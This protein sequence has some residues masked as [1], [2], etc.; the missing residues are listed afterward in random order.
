[1]SYREFCLA[2]GENSSTVR[3]MNELSKDHSNIAKMYYDM[4][5]IKINQ[6]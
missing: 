4:K 5:F 6:Y 3:Y 1:M 2:N